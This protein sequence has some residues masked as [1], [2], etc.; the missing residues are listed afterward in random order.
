MRIDCDGRRRSGLSQEL[1]ET[2][3]PARAAI[4]RDDVLDARA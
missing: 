4:E 1:I 2:D 3:D